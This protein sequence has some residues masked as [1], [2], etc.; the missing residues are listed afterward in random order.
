MKVL[1]LCF[2]LKDDLIRTNKLNSIY[3]DI[4]NYYNK[5]QIKLI[6]TSSNK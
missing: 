3:K 2:T 1:S 5:C 6:L 4:Y